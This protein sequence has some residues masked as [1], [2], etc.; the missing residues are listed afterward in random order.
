MQFW[1]LKSLIT[2]RKRPSRRAARMVRIETCEARQM[3]SAATIQLAAVQDTTIYQGQADTSNGA[4]EF[5]LAGD[6]KRGLVRF[7]VGSAGIPNGS[8]IIDAVLTLNATS[9]NQT[10]AAVSIHQVS[11]SWGE[12]GSNAPGDESTGAPAQQFDATWLYA[13]YDGELWTTAGGDFQGSSAATIVGGAGTYE[14]ISGG[15]IDD[16]QEWVDDASTNFGWAINVASSTLKSFISKDGPGAALS[17]SLEITYEEPPPPPALVEGRLWHDL[18]SDGVQVDP[19]LAQLKLRIV[20]G[21]TYY[22]GFG[23]G[24]YWFKSNVTNKWYFLTEDGT[25]TQWAGV[26]GSLTGDVVG[27]VDQKYY[28]EPSLVPTSVGDLE[29]WLNGWTV[30]L[31][32]ADGNVVQS[33]ITADRDS[34]NDGVID[35]VLEGGWYQFQVPDDVNYT[36]RQVL[37][38]GWSETARVS[39]QSTP[40]TVQNIGALNL[41]R[42]NSYYENFGGQG[43]KW[44]YSDV[45]GWY[46]I[47]PAGDLYRWNGRAITEQNPLSGTLIEAVGTAYFENPQLLGSYQ[48]DPSTAAGSRTDFGNNRA[49]TIEGRVWLDF[50]DNG[51]RDVSLETRVVVPSQ[52]IADDERWFFDHQ[53][54]AW[55]IIDSDGYAE[56]WGQDSSISD[57]GQSSGASGNLNQTAEPWLNGRTVELLDENGNVVATTVTS[58]IDRND[59]GVIDIETE[60]GW[61]EFKDVAAGDYSLRTVATGDWTQTAPIDPMQSFAGQLDEQFG[62]SATARDFLNWGGLNERWFIDRNNSW[63]YILPDGTIF[64]WEVGSSSSNGGLR[65]VLIAQVDSAYYIDLHLLTDPDLY[66]ASVSV[67]N[68]QSIR[69]ILFGNHKALGHLLSVSQ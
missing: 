10:S 56:Y 52:I 40:G 66:L 21:N 23:G 44:V 35:S 67:G 32:D 69:D 17:P 24:E 18:N 37:P 28:L 19:I 3:L 45:S 14:W 57:G 58:S 31:L 4:G 38:D 55:F 36:V 15:L 64:R 34:N 27:T 9:S 33:T 48:S 6:G 61:Y 60:R 7:D 43:E 12:S 39:F 54:D 2:R 68:G 63:Y 59:D 20:G 53:N 16:V 47:T 22:N 11:S 62:F 49:Y 46:F 13:S 1:N 30:E 8:T 65:G 50:Y 51:E 25:L 42:R 29:P 41:R 5:I 26:S